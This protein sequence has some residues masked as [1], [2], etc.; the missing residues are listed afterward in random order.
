MRRGIPTDLSRWDLPQDVTF[1]N[2]VLRAYTEL[3]RRGL[4]APDAFFRKVALHR[5]LDEAQRLG[6]LTEESALQAVA[7]AEYAVF[8]GGGR[9]AGVQSRLARAGEGLRRPLGPVGHVI[10]PF[11]RTPGNVVGATIDYSPFGAIRGARDVYRL[12]KATRAGASPAELRALQKAASEQLGRTITGSGG[13]F[14]G[15]Y[16]LARNGLM[17]GTRPSVKKEQDQWDLAGKQE[18]AIKFKDRWWSLN[19]LSP[20]GNLMA[21]GA[22]YY[23]IRQNPEAGE[24][25]AAAGALGSIGTTATEQS[26]LRGVQELKEGIEDPVGQGGRYLK[27]L[28][29]STVPAAVGATARA[30][31]PVVR[32]TKGGFLDTFLS[33]IPGQSQNL[34]AQVDQLGREKERSGG[35]AGQFLDPTTSREYKLNDPVIRELERT[36]AAIQE[37]GQGRP[38]PAEERKLQAALRNT[39][40]PYTRALL[41]RRL[42]SATGGESR[43]EY[44]TRARKEGRILNDVLGKVIRNDRYQGLPLEA[45]RE[46]LEAAATK[47][48]RQLGQ[49]RRR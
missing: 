17:T 12:I 22:N 27:N 10:A 7:D 32:D 46:V 33:R 25:G 15:G 19:R 11:T 30:V 34:P 47:V 40:S 43:E 45:Q 6:P 41:E 39:K 23:L 4:A 13:A 8:Q 20:I 26:F 37:L 5:A 35:P 24:L 9:E 3:I 2:P 21:L 31:D 49:A 36:G 18:N 42:E 48:R 44:L 29:A 28:A 1:K 16:I 14:L 38:R